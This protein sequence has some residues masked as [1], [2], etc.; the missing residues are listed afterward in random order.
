MTTGAEPGLLAKIEEAKQKLLARC[1]QFPK[2]VIV[3]EAA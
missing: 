1:Q 3:L 2:I